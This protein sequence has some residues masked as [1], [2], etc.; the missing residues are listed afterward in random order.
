MMKINMTLNKST[1]NTHVYEAIGTAIPSLYI[2]KHELPEPPPKTITVTVDH[3][4]K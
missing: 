4:Q 3:D 1:K 2:Q